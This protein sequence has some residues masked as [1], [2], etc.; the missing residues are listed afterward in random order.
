M[1]KDEA[2]ALAAQIELD[3]RAIR[4][5]L[6]Q[7]VA[8]EIDQ[9][10]LTGVQ[11]S[12]MR[13]ILQRDGISLKDLSKEL[14]LAHSTVSGLVD[15]LEKKGLIERQ[16]NAEDLRFNRIVATNDVR[17]FLQDRW[18]SLERQPLAE[19][20]H[21]ASKSDQKMVLNGISILRRLLEGHN[22]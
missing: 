9:G 6:H 15:R 4:Q 14:G 1:K 11:K 12:A 8:A 2:K 10:G 21:N 5:I 22:P 13:V 3:L 18:P 16:P 19:T 20:L 17:R 7:P